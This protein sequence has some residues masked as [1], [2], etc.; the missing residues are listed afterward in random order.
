MSN[1]YLYCN[2]CKDFQEHDFIG[3]QKIEGITEYEGSMFYYYNCSKCNN[4]NVQ[5]VKPTKRWRW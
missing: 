1:K 3:K 4:T 5:V 2:V